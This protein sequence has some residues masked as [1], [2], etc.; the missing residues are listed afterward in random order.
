MGPGGVWDFVHEMS[1]WQFTS[2]TDCKYYH[3]GT[4]AFIWDVPTDLDPLPTYRLRFTINTHPD[5]E[6]VSGPFRLQKASGSEPPQRHTASKFTLA[7]RM[8]YIV[9]T[10][11]VVLFVGLLALRMEEV[12]SWLGYARGDNEEI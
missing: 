4:M 9:C 10:L 5:E 1:A 2:N 6:H 8:M 3:L 12:V 7:R 11:L